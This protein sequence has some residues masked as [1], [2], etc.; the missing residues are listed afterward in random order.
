MKKS[1]SLTLLA[2]AGLILFSIASCGGSNEREA[3]DTAS[4]ERVQY[5]QADYTYGYDEEVYDTYAE[6][7]PA[8]TN[9]KAFPIYTDGRSPDNHYILSGYMGDYSDIAV[10]PS[11]F[12]N[13]HSGTTSIKTVY[14]NKVSQG[15]R[16]AGVYWQ[17]PANN[18]GDRQGGYDL[19]GAAKLSFWARGENGGERIEEF[20]IGGITGAYADSDV[21]GI[22]PV[23]LTKEWKQYEIDLRGKDLS[24]ISGG[25]CWATNLDVNPD[26]AT[27][28]LD[29]IRY[30]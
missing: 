1:L 17:N 21:A 5:A 26:G 30:E 11:S 7:E 20:K 28:Y 2:I 14:S 4:E 10:D 18:W 9:F 15:A 25:F 8:A 29:D 27:F 19:T 3:A 12:D 24:Y 22:G 6:E 23:L 13:P 16:W